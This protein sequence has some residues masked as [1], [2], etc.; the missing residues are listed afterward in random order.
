VLVGVVQ[1]F[2]ARLA[3]GGA[4]FSRG[5]IVNELVGFLPVKH[6]GLYFSATIVRE[7]NAVE[8]FS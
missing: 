5:K 8:A 7:S 3:G 6:T 4:L 2:F 1:Y